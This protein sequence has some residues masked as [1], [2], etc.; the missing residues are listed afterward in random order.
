MNHHPLARRFEEIGVPFRAR[1]HHWFRVDVGREGKREH[2]RFSPGD[3]DCHVMDADVEKKQ[4]LLFAKERA[5]DGRVIKRR[6]LCGQDER[7]LF[8]VTVANPQG[9]VVNTVR[10][11]HE[12]LKPIEVRKADGKVL[13]QGDWFFVPWCETIWN[14]WHVRRGRLGWGNPHLVDQM[15]G[16]PGRF[17]SIWGPTPGPVLARGF[18]RHREHK[19]LTLR[20][21]HRV[22]PNTGGTAPGNYVD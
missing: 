8:A 22:Y 6:I 4:L 17:H 11:A 12:A 7:S 16:H 18:V 20:I 21:W 2:I 3:A 13:R 14:G 1:D 15:V 19:P 5:W 10:A 9:M